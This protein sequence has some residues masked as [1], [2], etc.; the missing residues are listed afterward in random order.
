MSDKHDIN[1]Y[2]KLALGAS[3]FL[4]ESF[5][6][7]DLALRDEL[8]TILFSELLENIEPSKEDE[9]IFDK[10]N[11]PET[12]IGLLQS[13]SLEVISDETTKIMFD[14][15]DNAQARA[16]KEKY[17]FGLDHKIDSIQILGH[18]NNF[19]FFMETIINRH[20]LFLNQSKIID[21]PSYSKISVSRIMERIKYIFKDE[22]NENKVPLN[23][24]QNLFRLRN[25]T[26]HF[27]PDNAKLLKPKISQLMKIWTQCTKL[28]EK[29]EQKENFNELNFSKQI[30]NYSRGIQNKWN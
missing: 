30:I 15:W 18:L 7:L 6:Y 28:V 1:T 11:L 10:L 19:G 23:E 13:D 24:V 2:E 16:E 22:S 9:K 4:E 25:K 12:P 14:A 21:D 27:T 3:F 20:L 8:T 26:V 29:L 5:K 17:K